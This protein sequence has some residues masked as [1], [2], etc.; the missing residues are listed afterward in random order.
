MRLRLTVVLVCLLFAGGSATAN[1]NP[2]SE[3]EGDYV[4]TNADLEPL[5]QGSDG[6]FIDPFDGLGWGFVSDVLQISYSRLDADRRHWLAVRVTEAH[7]GEFER[8]DY[9]TFATRRYPR[10]RPYWHIP[11]INGIPAPYFYSSR[12]HDRRHAE[13]YPWRTVSGPTRSPHRR[14]HR[15]SAPERPVVP[16][17]APPSIVV[18]AV[19]TRPVDPTSS[20]V[21]PPPA[22]SN[23]PARLGGGT[24]TP[25]VRPAVYGSSG[26]YRTRPVGGSRSVTPSAEPT[27]GPAAKPRRQPPT[28]SRGARSGGV[29]PP[30]GGSA[31]SVKSGSSTGSRTRPKR[32]SSSGGR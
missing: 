23:R 1:P 5:P 11:T 18:P 26:T 22:V 21:K 4:Y 24:R 17:Y 29:S 28:R 20:D 10:L 8:D 3:L 15:A 16:R 30:K 27:R 6:Y 9:D 32:S 13:P 25:A 14:P 19:R 31:G 2:G 7:L 12:R